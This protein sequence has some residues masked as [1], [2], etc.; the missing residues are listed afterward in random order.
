MPQLAT[1]LL[2]CAVLLCLSCYA[3]VSESPTPPNT[4]SGWVDGVTCQVGRGIIQDSALNLTE[5]VWVGP[6][7]KKVYVGSP[8]VVQVPNTD[9]Y[10]SSHDFFFNTLD[11]T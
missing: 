8:A 9:T 11:V 5:I 6:E 1:K 2:V 4:C 10:L 3:C 7:N